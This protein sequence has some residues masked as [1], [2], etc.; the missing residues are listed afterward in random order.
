MPPIAQISNCHPDKPHFGKGLCSMCY[1]RKY[2]KC[3]PSKNKEATRK[4]RAQNN[5]KIR[6]KYLKYQYGIT[7]EQYQQLL[8]EQKHCC[9]LCGKTPMIIPVV[10]HNHI[11]GQIRGIVC[12]G[13][14]IAIGHYECFSHMFDTIKQ[15]LEV[16]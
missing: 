16:A 5:D 12:Q 1:H 10:D 11:T 3:N 14:N 6:N 8:E 15:Y 13:C 9:K 4:W 2:R 7:L